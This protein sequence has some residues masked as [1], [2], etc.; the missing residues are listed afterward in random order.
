MFLLASLSRGCVMR[1]RDSPTWL[2]WPHNSWADWATVCMT[3]CFLADCTVLHMKLIAAHGSMVDAPCPDIAFYIAVAKWTPVSHTFLLHNTILHIKSVPTDRSMVYLPRRYVTGHMPIARGTNV[4]IGLRQDASVLDSETVTACA[5]V[6]Y[7]ACAYSTG[8]RLIAVRTHVLETLAFPRGSCPLC[9]QGGLLRPV[10]V[11][12]C[13]T[14]ICTPFG[15][16]FC[17]VLLSALFC[18]RPFFLRLGALL[19]SIPFSFRDGSPDI[20][21]GACLFS[22]AALIATFA[23]VAATRCTALLML[24]RGMG[25]FQQL[26]QTWSPLQERCCASHDSNAHAACFTLQMLHLHQ[27]HALP[28][29]SK[30]TLP[31]ARARF[32]APAENFFSSLRLLQTLHTCVCSHVLQIR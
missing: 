16:H 18:L 14:Y 5:A 1:D 11:F 4:I 7:L 2:R 28:E 19:F 27:P 30:H 8:H 15:G 12:L 29:Q 32:Q 25:H 22:S 24:P 31:P 17:S 13:A 3:P 26:L 23:C 6:I 21:N 10:A 20:S 9:R